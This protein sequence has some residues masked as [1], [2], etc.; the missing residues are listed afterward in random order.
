[1][2]HDK[3]NQ[4]NLLAWKRTGRKSFQAFFYILYFGS[5]KNIKKIE[6]WVPPY[7][8]VRFFYLYLIL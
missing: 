3:R 8:S 2:V 5:Y 1:M 4:I 6:E 7:S